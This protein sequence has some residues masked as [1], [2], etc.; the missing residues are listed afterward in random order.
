MLG[1]QPQR[2]VS[3]RRQLYAPVMSRIRLVLVSRMPRPEEVC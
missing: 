1:M 2:I 3:P